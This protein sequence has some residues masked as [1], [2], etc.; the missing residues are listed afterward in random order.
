ME[1]ISFPASS[2]SSHPC[3][4]FQAEYSLGATGG[5]VGSLRRLGVVADPVVVVVST[6]ASTGVGVGVVGVGLTGSATVSGGISLTPLLHHCN[7]AVG[8]GRHNIVEQPHANV[9]LALSESHIDGIERWFMDSE[10]VAGIHE[11]K[12]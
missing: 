5:G 3:G 11:I 7:V 9:T 4:R 2:C 8:A 6:V 10:H 1:L 12:H